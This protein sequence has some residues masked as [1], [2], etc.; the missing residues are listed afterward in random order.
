MRKL[1]ENIY[2][3]NTLTRRKE[4]FVPL[5]KGKVKMYTCGPTVYDF[6]HIGNFRAF[7]F[8]DL[9]RRWLEYCGYKVIHVMNITDVDDKT[10]AAARKKGISLR[11]YTEHYT[12]AF[13]EDITALNIEKA[14][15]YPRATEHIPEMVALIKKLLEKGYAYRG[16]DGSIYYAISKFKDYGKLSKIRVKELKPGARVKV[17]EYGKEEA[18]DFALWKAWDEEDGDVF[19]ETELGKG[20]PGWHIECSAMSMKYLG[21]TFDIHC[22]GVDNIFPHHENEIA[23]SEAATGKQFVRYWLHNEYLLVEG[24]KMSKRFGNYY[25]LRDL[26]AKGYDPKAIRY[27]LMSTHYRQQLNFTFEGLEA[28]KNAV[29]RLTNFVYRLLDAD[30]EGCGEKIGSLME[31]VQKRFE[32]AMCDDLNIAVALAAIFNF[33]REVNKLMDDNKLSR[34]EAEQVYE[35]MMR[36]DKVLGV[37]GEVK[38]E[39][40]KLPKEAEELIRKREEARKVRDWETADKIR[41][42]LKAMGVIVEDTPQGVKW[43]IEKRKSKAE[44]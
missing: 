27:L 42:R 43:R 38:K 21:E 29:D 20:R 19:W 2:F 4:K 32:E 7:V 25:T 15:Y 37:I 23:Q 9:L 16:E 22:G 6:A 24:R 5:E 12:Q 30:G 34:G 10:I 18:H 41:E 8:E 28:A 35:L 1:V 14:H 26:L 36:F 11:E 39:E 40:E 33:V 17:D 31:N 44:P 3:F 13:F